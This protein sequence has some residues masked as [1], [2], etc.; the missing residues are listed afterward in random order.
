MS[1]IFLPSLFYLTT[2][3]LATLHADNITQPS[4]QIT[5]HEYCDFLNEVAKGDP[6]HLY[7]EKMSGIIRSGS[8]GFYTYI[9]PLE[10]ET[11]LLYIDPLSA[12]TYDMWLKDSTPDFNIHE[13]P[14]DQD[15][16]TDVDPSLK[17]NRRQINLLSPLANGELCLTKKEGR[18]ESESGWR[19]FLGGILSLIGISGNRYETLPEDAMSTY[20]L[21]P[22]REEETSPR[23]GTL[24]TASAVTAHSPM[25]TSR[26][27]TPSLPIPTTAGNLAGIKANWPDSAE[28][29]YN[30]QS[31]TFSSTGT[32]PE[33]LLYSLTSVLKR[34]PEDRAAH[35][36]AIDQI[37]LEVGTDHSRAFQK[38]FAWRKM[39]GEPV[40]PSEINTFVDSLQHNREEGQASR[41]FLQSIRRIIAS[42]PLPR[43][44]HTAEYTD[45]PNDPKDPHGINAVF[46]S[47]RDV[48]TVKNGYQSTT[49]D[50]NHEGK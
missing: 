24:M 39:I 38:Y 45:I 7:E 20:D 16:W 21:A 3:L 34:T 2:L 15:S 11:L 35:R 29:Q 37:A 27:L 48:P 10:E 33:K 9:V 13:Y 43:F 25:H 12:S 23:A 42:I 22:P 6:Y 14:I 26:S 8:S 30:P 32:K 49:N 44:S 28:I 36:A 46:R 50:P 1:K 5:A 40:T 18:D 4:L 47:K 17:S 41:D 19:R 31:K